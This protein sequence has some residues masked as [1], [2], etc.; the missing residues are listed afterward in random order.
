MAPFAI[1]RKTLLLC[2]DIFN[3]WSFTNRKSFDAMGNVDK[4]GPYQAKK[5][6]RAYAKCADL[7][8]PGCA[9]FQAGICS[10]SKHSKVS[11]YCL[12]IAKALIIGPVCI[13]IWVRFPHMPEDTFLHA[14][15]HERF[16]HKL[17]IL[18][19]QLK[20]QLFF[21]LYFY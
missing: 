9:N 14:A 3:I 15:A 7:H 10:P 11:N 2:P 1:S 4:H 16:K 13:L 17:F 5:C 6:L 21:Y 8:H 12:R 20:K 18:C 19:S